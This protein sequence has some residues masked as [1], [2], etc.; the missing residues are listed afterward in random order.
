MQDKSYLMI[1]GPTPV[2]P[3]VVA[4][5]TAPMFGHR[6][7]DFQ[8]MHKEIIG[9]LQKLFQTQNEIYVLT[10]SGT[11]GMESAVA[12]TVSPGD[13]VLTLVGGKFGERWS[14][15]A[16]QYGAEVI[17]LNYEWGTCVDPQAVQ[18]QLAANPDIKVVF[19][20]Q[21][22]TSTGV[23]NDIEALGKIV[24]QTPA[25]FVVDGVSGVGGIEI[26]VD[27]WNVDILTTGSQKSLMLP[28]GLAIQSI[29]DKAWKKIEEN[30]SPRYYFS[31]LKARKQ[32]PK[33]NT[34][35]T[36]AVSLFVGLN[37]ALDMIL[38]EGLDNVYARHKLLRDA[39]RAAIRALGLN[40]MTDDA[41][42]SPVVTS[43]YAPEGIGADDIRKV[44]KQEYNITFAG[45]QAKL[46]NKIFRIAHM[47]FADKMDVII[48][49]SGL[50][51]AL[52]KVGYPVE[53]G[54][55]VKAAQQVFL[56][57]QG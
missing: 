56:G 45:G 37:A 2:P 36:P 57:V 17:E 39:T 41:C 47:G 48:A 24:A 44:L 46:K 3:S 28:P 40:L 53:L 29:S 25:L 16:N 21:N 34:A 51:M 26:K 18:E 35:Y 9:K 4:A 10:S 7:E 30:K 50:E 13:K 1:P 38:N 11:G 14:E 32:Y 42:A 23:T 8:V 22:E 27:E 54:A 43:V 6:S 5:M 19:A 33:W 12:N 15:L 55:G 20:T 31:L 52:Q 49:V